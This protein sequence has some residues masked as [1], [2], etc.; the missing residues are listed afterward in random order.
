MRFLLCAD[1]SGR[2]YNTEV[3]FLSTTAAL[4]GGNLLYFLSLR[5]I[6]PRDPNVQ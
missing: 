5:T 4:F 3:K 1:L 6:A 2:C